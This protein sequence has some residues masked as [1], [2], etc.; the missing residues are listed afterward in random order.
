MITRLKKHIKPILKRE[1]CQMELGQVIVTIYNDNCI[2]HYQ[3]YEK[4]GIT[5]AL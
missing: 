1:Q 2:S 3:G 5:L 4:H